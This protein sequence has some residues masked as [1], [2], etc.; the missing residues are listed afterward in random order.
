MSN[1]IL[2]NIL[3][4]FEGTYIEMSEMKESKT[5]NFTLLDEDIQQ[6]LDFYR[7]KHKK[8]L[9]DIDI[10][11]QN[12]HPKTWKKILTAIKAK[13]NSNSIDVERMW[14][15]VPNLV[16]YLE[17]EYNKNING[18][19]PTKYKSCDDI[20]HL[21]DSNLGWFLH[22][23]HAPCPTT[24][25]QFEDYHSLYP[26]FD[27]LLKNK[28]IS[29]YKEKDKEIYI[30]YLASVCFFFGDHDGRLSTLKAPL[31]NL[32]ENAIDEFIQ[33]AVFWMSIDMNS[34]PKK[35]HMELLRK[36]YYSYV[37]YMKRRFP[38]E[39][40]KEENLYSIL[41]TFY[42]GGFTAGVT[43]SGKFYI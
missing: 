22:L 24:I 14:I 2:F 5:F 3:M 6:I 41:L 26:F 31:T 25:L 36:R 15:R 12:T 19:L 20:Q 1:L 8:H 40:R 28:E 29:K 7:A 42:K 32:D 39:S 35:R 13:T 16:K 4:E 34:E 27:K 9:T 38:I 18:E 23:H 33:K 37:E 17:D 30:D 11:I 43:M 21:F 10:D